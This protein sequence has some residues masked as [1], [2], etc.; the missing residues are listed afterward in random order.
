MDYHLSIHSKYNKC[1]NLTQKIP[2]Y[3]LK[4][5]KFQRIGKKIRKKSSKF[6]LFG[7]L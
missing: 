7:R 1:V 3:T 4:L 6:A 2:T 5:I